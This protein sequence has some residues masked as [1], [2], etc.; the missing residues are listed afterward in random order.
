MFTL[1]SF[2]SVGVRQFVPNVDKL[3]ALVEDWE[4][5]NFKKTDYTKVR[6]EHRECD[7]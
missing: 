4:F 6:V 1:F 2:S 5:L 3:V 7:V